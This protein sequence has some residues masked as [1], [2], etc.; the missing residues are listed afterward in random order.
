MLSP[1]ER[2]LLLMLKAVHDE[3]CENYPDGERILVDCVRE[4]IAKAE[5]LANLDGAETI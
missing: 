2:E 1:L 4:L 5:A 3:Y